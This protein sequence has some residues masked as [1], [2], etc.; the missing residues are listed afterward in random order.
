MEKL[1]EAAACIG[2][3]NAAALGVGC[4]TLAILIIWPKFFKTIPASLIAVLVTAGAVK[5]FRLPVNTIGDLYDISSGLPPFRLPALSLGT[6]TAV[7]PDAATIA[8]LAAIE[9]LLSCV[10]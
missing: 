2:T 6:V 5:L 9:S 8:V 3:L 7:L 10:D 1:A 4:L